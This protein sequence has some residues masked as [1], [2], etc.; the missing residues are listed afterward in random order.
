MR[1]FG[2]SSRLASA[3]FA[4][5]LLCGS[6][7]AKCDTIYE[8]TGLNSFDFIPFEND[9]TPNRPFGDHLGN[10]ITFAGTDRLLTHVQVA[11]ASIGPKGLNT[12]TLTLYRNDGAPDP[13]GSGLLQPGTEIASFQTVASNQPL[14]GNGG[15]GVDWNFAPTLVPDTLTAVI[16]SDYSGQFMG[17]FAAV[18]PPLVGS[19][20]NTVWYGDG[21]PGGWV[22]DS[23][24]AIVD[25]GVTNFFDMRFDAV[26]E[27]G[28]VGLTLGLGIPG[29]LLLLRRRKRS[30]TLSG[31]AG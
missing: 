6:A 9:G 26:P 27:P 10:T 11:F 25:G 14:P 4:V 17:P 28:S 7:V 29:I 24:W 5:L 20:I 15:Y 31:D 16:S 21:T 1:H 2:G 13:N 22:A 18:V 8:E 19:A 23:T 30:V 12:Y 3:G